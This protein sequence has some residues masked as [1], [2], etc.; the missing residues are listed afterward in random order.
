MKVI[1]T[2]YSCHC[3]CFISHVALSLKLLPSKPV[4]LLFNPRF[5]CIYVQG[6][7]T[8]GQ[9]PRQDAAVS[10]HR[11]KSHLWVKCGNSTLYFCHNEISV[12]LYFKVRK[13]TCHH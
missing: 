5:F 2:T 9:N 10:D 8:V 1:L 4:Q 13:H 6:S 12:F 7:C 11:A 3:V